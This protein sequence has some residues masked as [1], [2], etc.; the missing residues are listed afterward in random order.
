[1]APKAF[2]QSV[3]TTTT[4]ITK[5]L[6][7]AAP[8][9]TT[10]TKLVKTSNLIYGI[11]TCIILVTILGYYYRNYLQVPVDL[12]W[13]Y[14]TSV[15]WFQSVYFESFFATFCYVVIIPIYPFAFHFIKRF[16]KYKIE[17]SVNYVHQTVIG[18]II[19][20][21]VY[22]TPL[23]LMDTFMVKKYVG[24]DPEVWDEKRKSWI[25]TTRALPEEAPS[26][27]QLIFQL[28]GSIVV[29]DALFFCVHLAIHKN[30]WLY[31]N[32]HAVHHDH[33]VMNAHVTNQLSVSERIIL[34]LSANFSLKIF[35]SHPLTRMVFVPTFIFML[36]DNHMGYDLPFGM[37]KIVPWQ[38][39][40]GPRKHYQHHVHGGGDYQPFFCYLDKL[41]EKR[42]KTKQCD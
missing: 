40:G 37:D 24:I 21:F 17:P 42:R 41:L 20:G 19:Q 29:Y 12:T 16:D 13:R 7:K 36:V 11:R 33:E 10:D 30:F 18:M 3:T 25:Q 38:L 27:F 1:M 14:L 4:G 31:K 23:M 35:N 28:V 6:D 8:K 9:S 39:M 26:L 22:L 32:L 34:I 2:G 5:H 15:W